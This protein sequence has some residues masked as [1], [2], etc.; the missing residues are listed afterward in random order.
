VLELAAD[1][2]EATLGKGTRSTSTD[3]PEVEQIYLGEW[4]STPI[5]KKTVAARG[6]ART[7]GS[8]FVS[9]AEN[10][11]NAAGVTDGNHL[12]LW[13]YPLFSEGRGKPMLGGGVRRENRLVSRTRVCMDRAGGARKSVI[14]RTLHSQFARPSSSLVSSASLRVNPDSHSLIRRA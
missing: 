6:A 1:N 9:A 4:S 14:D 10:K 7:S 2:R 13:F 5:A 8:D 3:A 11:T 12:W